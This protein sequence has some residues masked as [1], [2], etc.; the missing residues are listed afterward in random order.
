MPMPDPDSRGIN[1]S[2]NVC[3]GP[4]MK[5]QSPIFI[6]VPTLILL[7]LLGCTDEAIL[8]LLLDEDATVG[9]GTGTASDNA[10]SEPLPEAQVAVRFANTTLNEAVNVQFYASSNILEQVPDDLFADPENLVTANLGVAGTGLI[11]PG[12]KDEITLDC[13]EN[14]IFGTLGGLFLDNESGD[15]R[16][17][18]E[19]R[20][21]EQRAL[22]VCGGTVTFMFTQEGESYRTRLTVK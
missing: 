1:E 8:G 19:R 7:L 14:L 6:M 20:W 9:A 5:R 12:E 10:A 11:E 2:V 17:N 3:G 16:G 15:E 13:D 22:G 21:V 18:G 4:R